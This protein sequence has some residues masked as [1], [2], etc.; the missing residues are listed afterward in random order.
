LRSIG[1]RRYI[2]AFGTQFEKYALRHQITA[3]T[4]ITDKGRALSQVQVKTLA[5]ARKRYAALVAYDV[6]AYAAPVGVLTGA[7]VQT[8]VV[9]DKLTKD[10]NHDPNSFRQIVY[11]MVGNILA[12]TPDGKWVFLHRKSTPNEATQK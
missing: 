10:P 2:P 11:D 6:A 3:L 5:E 8:A 7:T 9:T 4:E 12:Q 1:F